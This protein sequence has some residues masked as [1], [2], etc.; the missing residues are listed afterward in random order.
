MIFFQLSKCSIPS[1][2]RITSYFFLILREDKLNDLKDHIEDKFGSNWN[3]YTSMKS[4]N[5]NVNGN[6]YVID[7]HS[8]YSSDS[9]N[10]NERPAEALESEPLTPLPNQIVD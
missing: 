10:N 8:D 3:K 2:R 6:V 1:S 4:G 5:V 9:N 7:D